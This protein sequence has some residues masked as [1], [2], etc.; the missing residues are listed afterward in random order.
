MEPTLDEAL[1]EAGKLLDTYK[2][3]F[4]EW[5]LKCLRK[6]MEDT[7]EY[8]LLIIEVSENLVATNRLL[9]KTKDDI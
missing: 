9:E 6:L 2:N 5:Q 3:V 1:N 7:R 4:T 8:R